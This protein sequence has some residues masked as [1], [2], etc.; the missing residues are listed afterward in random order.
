M[1]LKAIY[2]SICLFFFAADVFAQTNMFSAVEYTARKNEPIEIVAN[3]MEAFQ[4]KKMIV[5]SGNAVA[6]Q[7]DITLKTERL[8]V[9]YKN[10]AAKTGKA[11]AG[12]LQAGG[13]LD[14]IEARGNVVITQKELSATAEEAVYHHETARFVL[15][16]RPVLKQSNN[17]VSGCKVFIYVNEN[18][19][20]V[21]KCEGEDPQRVTAIIHPQGKNNTGLIDGRDTDTK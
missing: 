21:V 14:R 10:V 18:R 2:I 20:E 1:K 17:T 8:A 6:R 15:T 12:E 4:G 7:G 5:F 19:G 3:K 9:Y 11:G 13:E 16:G